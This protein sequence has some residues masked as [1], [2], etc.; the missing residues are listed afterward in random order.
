MTDAIC[1]NCK[2]QAG[3]GRFCQHCGTRLPGA[4]VPAALSR[5]APAG[6]S[7]PEFPAGLP[8]DPAAFAG[9]ARVLPV[10]DSLPVLDAVRPA[11][12]LLP[13]LP[14]PPPLPRFPAAAVP[15]A[16]GPDPAVPVAPSDPGP[17]SVEC[18]VPDRLVEGMSAALLFRLR[19]NGFDMAESS[20]SISESGNPVAG[21][22][23]HRG[24]LGLRGAELSLNLKPSQSGQV[25][26]ELRVECRRSGSLEKEVWTAPLALLVEPASAGGSSPISISIGGDNVG[27]IGGLL[28]G[29]RPGGD[30]LRTVANPRR[31]L[32]VRGLVLES[33]PTRLTLDG[34]GRRL[35]LVARRPAWFGRQCE[36]P[37]KGRTT[38]NAV[39][40]RVFSSD[41]TTRDDAASN[42]ISRTHFLVEPD[43]Q[44]CRLRDGYPARDASGNILPGG[45]VGASGNG[46]SV[47]GETLP[48]RGSATFAAGESATVAVAP[49]SA[50]SP[51]LALRLS[52]PRSASSRQSAAGAL[53]RRADSVPESYLA[54]WAEADLGE[55]EESLRGHCVV[56]DGARFCLRC[57]DGSERFLAPGLSFGPAS[58]RVKV[59]TFR[60]IGF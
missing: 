58:F 37:G 33:S 46:T 22:V 16:A 29:V 11:L 12:P 39:V 38:D 42:A 7:V 4:A 43:G 41:G 21:P 13:A 20:V 60:Q 57:P 24:M 54:L 47:N 1:P 17:L 52:V 50:G 51:V 9:A 56:W 14:E 8:R 25:V 34:G 18:S 44:R 48:G 2:M 55:I 10:P 53:L 6:A 28:S 27:D 49:D 5:P 59:E 36:K 32:P 19:G 45:V 26:V 35:H 23:S 15:P 3:E 31:F 30:R 40:L